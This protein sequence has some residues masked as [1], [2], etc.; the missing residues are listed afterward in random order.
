MGTECKN[1]QVCQLDRYRKP[2]CRCNLMCT[3]EFKAVCG[4]DGK[5]YSNK[6]LMDMEACKKR[7]DIS[8]IFNGRCQDGT[9]TLLY[10]RRGVG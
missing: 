6:C 9:F 4:S 2:V 3:D 8:V 5:T 7:A 1:G 10:K